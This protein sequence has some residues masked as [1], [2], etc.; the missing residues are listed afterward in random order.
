LPITEDSLPV[1]KERIRELLLDPNGRSICLQD[2][3]S[4][5][6]IWLNILFGDEFFERYIGSRFTNLLAKYSN[7]IA[8]DIWL[9]YTVAINELKI[10]A[11]SKLTHVRRIYEDLMKLNIFKQFMDDV[12][13]NARLSLNE[14]INQFNNWVE[15]CA[16]T[17]IKSYREKGEELRLLETNDIVANFEYLKQSCI[18]ALALYITINIKKDREF[19]TCRWRAE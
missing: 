3:S 14:Y 9:F 16:N 19:R 7:V 15:T 5:L 6:K 8:D 4:N 12:Y 18:C 1:I 10:A 11:Q 2:A 13:N 17:V